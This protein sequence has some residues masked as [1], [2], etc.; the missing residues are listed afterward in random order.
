MPDSR[1]LLL[2]NR[3]HR[4][5]EWDLDALQVELEKIDLAWPLPTTK[6]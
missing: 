2:L 3:Q 5:Y 1:H 4:L 6:P